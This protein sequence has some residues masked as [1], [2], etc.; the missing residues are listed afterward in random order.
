VKTFD[1]LNMVRQFSRVIYDR[2]P[3][4]TLPEYFGCEGF[5][6]DMTSAYA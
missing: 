6:A 1:M 5:E 4:K 2:R 3:I